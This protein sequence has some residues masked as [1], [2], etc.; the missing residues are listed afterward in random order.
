[1]NLKRKSEILKN[2]KNIISFRIIFHK[3]LFKIMK[4]INI[5][6]FNILFFYLYKNKKIIIINNQKYFNRIIEFENKQKITQI[7]IQ[8]FHKINS[9]NILLEQMKYKRNDNPDIS[10][11][12]TTYNQGHCIY[13]CLRSIQNQS[14]KNLEIIIIDDCSLDNSTE[15]IEDF[16]K[17]DERIILLKHDKNEGTIK[18]R[19]DGIKIAKGKYIT[20]IDGDDSLI[21]K[22]ILFNSLYIANLANLDVVE[23][24]GLLY[25]NGKL[26][27][28]AYN[29]NIINQN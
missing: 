15:I 19:V 17:N 22:N 16:Q 21:H 4:L 13:K 28:N 9:D 10:I 12:I 27:G 25:I 3:Y 1:M 11:I 26:K 5:L 14:A 7:E 20:I 6:I 2:I 8:K 18:T 29:Y 23:F 24:K